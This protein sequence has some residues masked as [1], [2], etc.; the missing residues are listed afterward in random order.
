MF[1][2]LEK[3]NQTYIQ[4]FKDT[5]VYSSLSLYASCIFFIHGLYPDIL[6]N[7]GSEIIFNLNSMIQKK[8]KK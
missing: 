3:I 5:L 1:A 6:V 2:H 7:D 4:H 8:L